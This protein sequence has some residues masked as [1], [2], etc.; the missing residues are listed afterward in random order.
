MIGVPIFI[1]SIVD[2]TLHAITAS[3]AVQFQ[4]KTVIKSRPLVLEQIQTIIDEEHIVFWDA[5]R[6][7]ILFNDEL[8]GDVLIYDEVIG[9]V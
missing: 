9:D 3:S 8:E 4:C 2:T 7:R 1:N 6:Q 5:P